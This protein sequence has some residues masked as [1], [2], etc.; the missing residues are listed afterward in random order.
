MKLHYQTLGDGPP[1]IILHGLFGS[2]DNWL[3]VARLL[4]DRYRLLLPDLRNHG[5]SPHHDEMDYDVMAG[6]VHELIESLRLDSVALVGHS[7]GG[8]VAMNTALKWPESVSALVVVD[9][10]PK[11]YE[12]RHTAILDAMLSLRLEAFETRAQILEALAPGIPDIG[13]RQFLLKSLSRKDHGGYEWRLNLRA[14]AEHYSRINAQLP[15]SNPWGGRA[16]FLR[17]ARSNYILPED[18]SIIRAFFP[19]A[20]LHTVAEADHWVHADAPQAVAKA[21]S[22][23]FGE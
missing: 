23:F 9:I 3:P 12:P 7:M 4:Q 16:L 8:K 14:I 13:V 10:A 19:H 22:S 20:R 15:E 5:R 11:H 6:D 17:G 2:H 21:I 18:E 1:V